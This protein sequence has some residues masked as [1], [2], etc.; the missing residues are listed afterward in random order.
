MFVNRFPLVQ[1]EFTRADSYGYIKE[2]W[3]LETRASACTL[4]RK[5]TR[6]NSSH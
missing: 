4:D 1:M 2:V 3:G 5:S 6:L